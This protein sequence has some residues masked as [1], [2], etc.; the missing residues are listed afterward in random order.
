MKDGHIDHRI[1]EVPGE[2]KVKWEG[3]TNHYLSTIIAWKIQEGEKIEI[4]G[5][6]QIR[7]EGPGKPYRASSLYLAANASSGGD[8][9]Q[10]VQHLGVKW[11]VLSPEGKMNWAGASN[12]EALEMVSVREIQLQ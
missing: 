2:G 7:K 9:V 3:M 11:K 10:S 4:G 6:D 8:A 1:A 12:G 5:Q